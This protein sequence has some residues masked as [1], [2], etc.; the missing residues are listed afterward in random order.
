MATF[1]GLKAKTGSYL[2]SG[3]GHATTEP[4]QTVTKIAAAPAFSGQGPYVNK[5]PIELLSG[6]FPGLR[7]RTFFEDFYNTLHFIP[8]TI[9]LG[10]V[11]ADTAVT[12]SIWNAYL[13]PVTLESITFIDQAGV[14]LEGPPLPVTLVPLQTVVYTVRASSEGPPAINAQMIFEFDVEIRTIPV[15]GTRARMSPIVPNWANSFEIEYQFKTDIFSSRWGREQRRALRNTPRKTISF[16]ASP[17]H[18]ELRAARGLFSGWANNT[19]ILPELPRQSRLLEPMD[20]TDMAVL[21]EAAPSWMAVGETV[22]LAYRGRYDTREIEFVD[23]NLVTFASSVTGLWPVGTKIHPALSVRL[24]DSINVR[25]QTSEAAT[26]GIE[27][28]VLPG[29]EFYPPTPA[30]VSFKGREVWLTPPNWASPVNQSFESNR[31]LVDFGRGRNQVFEPIPFT[32]VLQKMGYSGGSFAKAFAIAEFFLR[33][34][35]Q[36]GE[37]Y[38]PTFVNDVLLTWPVPVTSRS[39]RVPG[40]DFARDYAGDPVRKAVAIY[41]RNGEVHLRGVNTIAQV[42][43]EIGLDSSIELDDALPYELTADNVLKI[44]WMPVWR[45]ATDTFSLEWLTTSVA[46]CQLSVRMIEDL[47]A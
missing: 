32:S 15:T 38:M 44:S 31:E 8:A 6:V 5:L 45:M 30:P 18:D 2:P 46:Q 9:E 29:S 23:G 42:E 40:T 1:P 12:L 10:A 37:F 35:G 27:F 21:R 36:L 16:T 3:H 34:K 13:Q 17:T 47:P 7:A 25:H 39:I 22:V 41:M 11:S 43:D 24:A 28:E 14:T 26:I 20:T 33:C 4:Q 19:I